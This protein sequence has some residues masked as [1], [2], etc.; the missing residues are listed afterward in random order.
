MAIPARSMTNSIRR[1][2]IYCTGHFGYPQPEDTWQQSTY[3]P[4]GY[5]LRCGIGGVQK[6]PFRF[7]SAK[8][9]HS[10]FVQLNWVFDEFFVRP[11]V[12][13]VF[14]AAGITGITFGPAVRHATGEPLAELE[15]LVIKTSVPG[16][17]TAGLRTVTCRPDNEEPSSLVLPPSSM[18]YT[19]DTPYCGRVKYHWPTPLRFRRNALEG[20]L[21]IVKSGEWLGSGGQ[22]SR[23]VLVSPR[24]VE[25]LAAE[26]WRG[27]K[28][29]EVELVDAG[30]LPQGI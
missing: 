27:V 13:E 14:D 1:Y 3:D 26:R 20:A 5:C 25:I 11:V 2:H 28:W 4:A 23:A 16:L 18:R 22:A 15:Q 30:D 12:R 8:A 24:I 10:Q 6:H 19:P 9:S 17:V 29:S 21:D 7:R